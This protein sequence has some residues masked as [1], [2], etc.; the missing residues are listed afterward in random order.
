MKYISDEDR[1]FL[2]EM[3]IEN[4]EGEVS[5]IFFS[6]S[7]SDSSDIAKGLLEEVSRLSEKIKL[8]T[9]DF[10]KDGDAVKKYGIS[11]SPAI[12]LVG[13]KDYGIRYYGVPIENEF[14]SLIDGII[15]VSTGKTELDEPTK[16]GLSELKS[17]E[18]I[19]VLVTFDC[20][21][22]SE[23]VKTVME[24]SVESEVITADIIDI[25]EFP[26]VKKEFPVLATPKVI[27]P[28]KGTLTGARADEWSILELIK[29]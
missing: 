7:D 17:P 18:K 14:N 3:F 4:L 8:V 25:S 24:L 19:I 29:R 21:Y 27:I 28:K 5:L 22:C 16:K 10:H 15:R 9:F 20:I 12:A 11:R 1:E 23:V 2:R 6:N 13:K 26:E